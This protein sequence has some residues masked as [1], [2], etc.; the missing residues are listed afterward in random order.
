[1]GIEGD[2]GLTDDALQKQ[3]EARR[4]RNAQIWKQK[5]GKD[6][7]RRSPKVI[8]V[9]PGNTVF[10][11]TSAWELALGDAFRKH[12]CRRVDDRVLADIRVTRD[13]ANK[14]LGNTHA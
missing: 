9:G 6:Q 10:V 5:A 2:T 8:A 4:K 7:A 13:P 3:L 1:M 12:R 14:P 11:E